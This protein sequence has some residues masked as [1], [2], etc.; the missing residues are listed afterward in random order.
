MAVKLVSV[1]TPEDAQLWVK[2]QKPYVLLNSVT[3]NP[4]ELSELL[5]VL[6]LI[7]VK[8]LLVTE[9]EWRFISRTI[10]RKYIS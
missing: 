9:V 1:C 10:Y 4:L 7:A 3:G 5:I 8:C 2:Q 6:N